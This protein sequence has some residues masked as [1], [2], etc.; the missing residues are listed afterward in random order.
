[1]SDRIRQKTNCRAVP[2]VL[3]VEE[4]DLAYEIGTSEPLWP[5][6]PLGEAITD[7]MQWC[8]V[9]SPP[10]RPTWRSLLGHEAWGEPPPPRVLSM[11]AQPLWDAAFGHVGDVAVVRG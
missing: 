6:A 9:K 4:H 11:P 2:N 5:A 7:V 10:G 8:L 1:M 3:T